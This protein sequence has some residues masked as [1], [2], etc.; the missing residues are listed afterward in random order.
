MFIDGVAMFDAVA[1]GIS[2]V[3]AALMDPQQRL[4]LETATEL[5]LACR[6]DASNEALRASWGV[7]VVSALLWHGPCVGLCVS[8]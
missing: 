8:V 5:L 2:E 7:F 1:L 4:L 6:D 3:E